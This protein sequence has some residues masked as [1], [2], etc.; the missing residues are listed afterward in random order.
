[1]SRDGEERATALTAALSGAAGLLTGEDGA[2]R[3][4]IGAVVVGAFVGA[5]VA[6][7]TLV[8][9]RAGQPTTRAG[10]KKAS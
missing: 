8:R 3:S 2:S 4:F 7:A 1:V 9:S 5:A 10:P 6:G